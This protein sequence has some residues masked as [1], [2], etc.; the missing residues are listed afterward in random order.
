MGVD[1]IIRCRR[2]QI[3][4]HFDVLEHYYPTFMPCERN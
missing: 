3:C 4:V 1:L 2:T